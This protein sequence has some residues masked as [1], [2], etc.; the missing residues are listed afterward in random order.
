MEELRSTFQ[1]LRRIEQIEEEELREVLQE[2]AQQEEHRGN[3]QEI[4]QEVESFIELNREI[5]G[6]TELMEEEP[7]N[8]RRIYSKLTSLMEKHENIRGDL[9]QKLEALS[10]PEQHI[11]I[12]NQTDMKMER[13]GSEIVEELGEKRFNQAERVLEER[14]TVFFEA[15]PLQK[16]VS[17]VKKEQIGKGAEVPGVFGFERQ[18]SGFRLIKFLELENT[19]PNYGSFSLD[20]QVNYVL[21]RF[22][23][24][25]NIIVA[26][27]HPVGD[28]SHSGTDKDL[29]R[30]ANNIGVIG[31]PDYHNNV[32]PVP[33]ALQNGE[34]MNLSSKVVKG[35]KVLNT[36]ELKQSFPQ[37][38]R[39]NE[40]L[41]EAVAKRKGEAW[42][43][44]I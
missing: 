14:P 28:F 15:R 13:L 32:Y 3:V 11:E 27:S 17:A 4:Y 38:W 20:E 40:A 19:D 7:G 24:D 16:F 33:Q 36:E 31:V 44:F 18:K 12:F 23:N 22:G 35:N 43:N 26:H 8:F 2:L 9:V 42:P 6:L 21:E 37:V 10:I 29:I 34:W 1:G 30:K 25:R 5:V 39:Y 41:K